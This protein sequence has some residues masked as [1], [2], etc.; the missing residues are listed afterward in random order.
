MPGVL[1]ERFGRAVEKAIWNAL[2]ILPG[3]D[4]IVDNGSTN[5][6]L[7]GAEASPDGSFGEETAK[8]PAV[9]LEYGRTQTAKDL[10]KKADRYITESEGNVRVVVCFKF[11]QNTASFSVYEPNDNTRRTECTVENQ[12]CLCLSTDLYSA[13]C[14]LEI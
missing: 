9:V 8:F 12:V 4:S 14:R 11:E 13:D 3:T 2:V 5:V 10:K 7:K 1:H 6:L